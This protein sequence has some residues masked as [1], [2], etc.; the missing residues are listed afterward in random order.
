MKDGR[1]LEARMDQSRG[2]RENPMSD[3]DVYRK[4]EANAVR[5]LPAAQV[6]RLWD[7][8]LRLDEA[9]DVKS[10]TQLLAN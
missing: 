1:R 8:G 3:A 9:A 5:A 4:F 7:E 10:F 2:S 6:R